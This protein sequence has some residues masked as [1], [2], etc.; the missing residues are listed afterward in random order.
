MEAHLDVVVLGA[1]DHQVLV[2]SR[3]IHSQTHDWTEV[4]DE[5]PGGGESGKETKHEAA[6]FRPSWLSVGR[7]IRFRVETE[8]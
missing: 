6:A 4:T 3:L 2:V 1:G 8:S 5:L 7:S